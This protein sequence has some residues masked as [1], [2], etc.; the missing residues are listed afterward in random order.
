MTLV[1]WPRIPTPGR[2]DARA[3]SKVHSTRESPAYDANPRG[4]RVLREC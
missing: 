3:V 1:A 4:A 2:T